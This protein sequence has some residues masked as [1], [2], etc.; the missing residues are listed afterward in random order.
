M[1]TRGKQNRNSTSS[2]LCC[3]PRGRPHCAGDT[4]VKRLGL[5]R[6][7]EL[8]SRTIGFALTPFVIGRAHSIGLVFRDGSAIEKPSEPI[9]SYTST[10]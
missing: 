4:A 1:R 5:D 2:G 10:C 9:R 7:Q 6:A 3:L 8:A